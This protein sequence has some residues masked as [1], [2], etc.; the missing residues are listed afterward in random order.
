MVKIIIYA[1]LDY[2]LLVKF[3]IY[4]TIISFQGIKK[5]IN[6]ITNMFFV[7]FNGA[8]EGNR[9]PACKFI[10]YITKLQFVNLPH[11]KAKAWGTIVCLVFYGVVLLY[12]FYFMGRCI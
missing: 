11:R 1:H 8:N 12:K 3:Y 5:N 10:R 2:L 4:I 6:K 9:T 7:D